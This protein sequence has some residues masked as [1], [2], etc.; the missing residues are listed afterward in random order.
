MHTTHKQFLLFSLI[1]CT[2]PT[3][4][5]PGIPYPQLLAEAPAPITDLCIG[6]HQKDAEVQ[7]LCKKLN[8]TITDIKESQQLPITFDQEYFLT[9][10]LAFHGKSHELEQSLKTWKELLQ[11]ILQQAVHDAA[12]L[13]ASQAQAQAVQNTPPT[14]ISPTTETLS[15]TSEESV[16]Q[17]EE[18]SFDEFHEW[19]F[20]N[21]PN[22]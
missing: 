2:A 21:A 16:D 10:L 6:Q 19:L 22:N 15:E 7:Y 17:Q 18:S 9:E 4:G 3:Y 14:S 12:V 8:D 20:L 1:L 11:T 13:K 5:V